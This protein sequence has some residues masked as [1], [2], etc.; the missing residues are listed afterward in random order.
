MARALVL[1]ST[2]EPLCVVSTRRAVVLVL[3]HKAEPL[4]EGEEAFHSERLDLQIP[5]VI[6]L[7]SYVRVPY[8]TR[9]TLSR[10]GVFARD[11]HQCQYCGSPAQNIDHVIPR[12]RGGKHVWE[13]VVAACIPCNTRKEAKSPR[14]AGMRLRS[15]PIAPRE[16]VWVIVAV[17]TIDP[18]WEPFLG[19]IG[20]QALPLPAGARA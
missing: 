1:N 13:N 17:G 20:K 2:Y 4:A 8:R 7:K 5:T 3:K 14:Q 10:R 9:A 12:S 11:N 16:R 6:R 15:T 19:P 18:A